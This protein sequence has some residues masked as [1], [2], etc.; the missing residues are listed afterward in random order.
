MLALGAEPPFGVRSA[1]LLS[2]EV[3]ASVVAEDVE[4][5]RAWERRRAQLVT[6]AAEPTMRVTVATD[7]A[8]RSAERGP[9][10]GASAVERVDLP[11]EKKRP[12]GK[13]FGTLVHAVLANV[14]LD[15]DA[16]GVRVV[17]ELQG[18]VLGASAAEVGRRRR[19]SSAK[20]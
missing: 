6:R 7:R 15:V 8:R 13:R 17:A 5:Y 19:R 2:K 4:R 18:C 9:S 16:Y 12:S 20:C 14:P 11:R 1:E 3:D 10:A